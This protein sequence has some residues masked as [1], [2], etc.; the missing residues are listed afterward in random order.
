[1]ILEEQERLGA[2]VREPSVVMYACTNNE[3][4]HFQP[5]ATMIWI[6]GQS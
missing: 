3:C 5:T 6:D 1:M 2:H 4:F